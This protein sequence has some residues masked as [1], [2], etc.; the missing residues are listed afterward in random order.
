MSGWRYIAARLNGD[1]TETRLH[2][3]VPISGAT[4]DEE[5]SGYGGIN[6][7]V[8]PEIP[9]LKT[10]SG[11]PIFVPWS[12]AIY[13]EED[14]QIRAG[15]IFTRFA[16][17]EGELNI[18]TVGF[19]AYAA[20]MPYTA[21]EKKYIGV[22]GLDAVRFLWGHLQDQRKGNLG[23]T[24]DPLKSGVKFGTPEKKKE[25][26]TGEGEDVSFVSGPLRF[27][28]W[29]TH[30]IGKEIDDLATETPFDWAI[31]H[32]WNDAKDSVTH[33]MRFGVPRLGKRRHD[34]RFAVGENVIAVP[35]ETVEGDDWFSDY[36]VLGA[37]EGSKMVRG[38]SGIS[39][40]R[41]RRV[42]VHSDT[43]LRT[44][45]AAR[46]RAEQLL[47]LN[48]DDGEVS[49]ALVVDS[50]HAP[51]GSYRVGDDIALTTV[52]GWMPSDVT[53]YRILGITMEPESGVNR[54]S[55]IRSEKV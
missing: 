12:T 5:L 15:A 42:G 28:I 31:D 40:N 17:V 27:A 54:L 38:S 53:W 45:T 9:W 3:D 14:G 30:D 8:K 21:G 50:P 36:L 13:A 19:G 44:S 4:L 41:L 1:G 32:Q 43:T 35:E 48:F 29:Q 47:K 49:D 24:F 7:T 52:P 25:F 39:H 2:N 33:H 51:N 23:I 22:D 46:K 16:V 20:G 34:L 55:L 11:E 18:E 6:G 10:S 26:T 37:G